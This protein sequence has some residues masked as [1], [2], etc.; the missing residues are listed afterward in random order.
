MDVPG[1]DHVGQALLT[2]VEIAT[3]QGW[4]RIMYRA[5]ESQGADRGP[6]TP[7]DAM[8]R[9]GLA[10]TFFV[11]F[12]TLGGFVFLKLFAGVVIDKFNRLRDERSG[13]AFM[14]DEQKEWVETRKLIQ[15][16]RPL[17][18]ETPPSGCIRR[19]AYNLATHKLFELFVMLM[20]IL[21]VALMAADYY[22][23]VPLSATGPRP[24]P[25]PFVME[26]L[27]LF[28]SVFFIG[29]ASIKLIGLSFSGY[30]KQ[31]WVRMPSLASD[32]H[33]LL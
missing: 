3:L 29:E 31:G 21:N 20:I 4:S 16:I 17:T 22:H 26:Y 27:N 11:I 14:S 13:M 10:G 24:E 28:F 7:G 1:F 9:A 32:R 19:P 8:S 33:R 12:V 5:M 15:T 18:I 6:V 2:L 30:F 23:A 25:M